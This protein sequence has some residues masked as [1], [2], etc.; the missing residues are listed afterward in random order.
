[1]PTDT[2]GF[3]RSQLEQYQNQPEALLGANEPL[4]DALQQQTIGQ[5]EFVP[6]GTIQ[7]LPNDCGIRL[8][9]AAPFHPGGQVFR[10][11]PFEPDLPLWKKVPLPTYLVG[12]M[13]DSH[14]C[15][16]GINRN[17]SIERPE[18]GQN[19]IIQSSTAGPV[20]PFVLVVH[21][22]TPTIGQNVHLCPK[23][24]EPFYEFT[25][26]ETRV[27]HHQV[28]LN[29]DSSD[30]PKRLEITLALLEEWHMIF[31]LQLCT[32]RLQ[33]THWR[34]K[35][36]E[37]ELKTVNDIFLGGNYF[38]LKDSF[39]ISNL[40]NARKFAWDEN[41]KDRHG[42]IPVWKNVWTE[43]SYGHITEQAFRVKNAV[44]KIKRKIAQLQSDAVAAEQNKK[45][46]TSRGGK[47]EVGLLGEDLGKAMNLNR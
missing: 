31:I 36:R 34:T 38:M 6:D 11:D 4:R 25:A 35:R 2:D 45:R 37:W 1:M 13:K 41:E 19:A 24:F 15:E 9:R 16:Q 33:A 29:A 17:P 42:S 7:L 14:A 44:V 46:K 3:K 23:T 43:E 5:A 8:D 47:I 20:P 12:K 21:P 22:P 30:E 32:F 26:E 39:G 10:L 27:D 28:Q 18:R 40:V